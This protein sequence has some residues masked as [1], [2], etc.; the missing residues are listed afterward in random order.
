MWPGDYLRWSTD[1]ARLAVSRKNTETLQCEWDVLDIAS[2]ERTRL[3]IE[4]VSETSGWQPDDVERHRTS[5]SHS[6]R[7]LA[8]A[9]LP[10]RSG[11]SEWWAQPSTVSILDLDT[12]ETVR[13]WQIGGLVPAV[14]W[15]AGD[16][17]LV[18]GALQVQ[19]VACEYPEFGPCGIYSSVW[20]LPVSG[21]GESDDL[22]RPERVI[23]DGFLVEVVT[24]N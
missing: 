4:A 3:P 6:G 21:T 8:R 7:Y 20:R 24:V 22:N 16:G 1:G 10:Q 15:S 17:W 18:L 13:E 23:A 11:E 14:R 19:D 9:Q 2:G 5:C 12:G